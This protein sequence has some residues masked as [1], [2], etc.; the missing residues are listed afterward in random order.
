[1][2]SMVVVVMV[3]MHVFTCVPL[4]GQIFLIEPLV[5]HHLAR[6]F[7]RTGDIAIESILWLMVVVVVVV[8]M[9]MMVS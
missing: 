5:V 4:I 6:K 8:I 3:M 1:M 9:M 7:F 2:M